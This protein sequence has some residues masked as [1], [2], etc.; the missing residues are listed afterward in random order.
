PLLRA[1]SFSGVGLLVLATAFLATLSARGFA[2]HFRLFRLV[3]E[4]LH[5]ARDV[6]QID[7]AFERVRERGDERVAQEIDDRRQDVDVGILDL[8]AQ[9]NLRRDLLFLLVLEDLR[10]D[11]DE[12]FPHFAE[13]PFVVVAVVYEFR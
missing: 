6:A 1:G 2:I 8:A 10:R 12:A 3:T 7:R 5:V 9:R 4:T 11:V 13:R